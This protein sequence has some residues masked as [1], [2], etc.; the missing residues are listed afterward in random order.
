MSRALDRSETWSLNAADLRAWIGGLIGSGARVVAPA[1]H[2]GLW[3]FRPLRS[4]EELALPAGFSAWSPKEFLFPRTETLFR[5]E[6]SGGELGLVDPAREDVPQVLFGLAPCDAAG[7]A[8]LD[9]VLGADP[10]YASRRALT[11]VV[12]LACDRARPE[13]FCTTVGGS[14]QGEEG[15]DL[16]LVANDETFLLRPLTE[17]GASLV[18]LASG[19]WAPA[20]AEA[21]ERARARLREVAEA[22]GQSPLARGFA[23]GLEERF[24][25]PAWRQVGRR[26]LGCSICTYVCP[27]C[28][29]FDVQDEGSASCGQRCRVWDS[30]TFGLFTLH[31]SGHNPR[32]SQAARYRQ[33]VLHK[34]SSYPLEHGGTPM[35]VGCGRCVRLCPAGLDVRETVEQVLAAGKEPR[36]AGA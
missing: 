6:V 28:S 26:C 15:G 5:Y 12:T 14:P 9:S 22:V 30:C 1:E 25:S 13:C 18:S 16:L 23:E 32:P 21:W 33:R 35:C 20:T 8:R 34:F 36:H 19:H 7:L 17:K 29:C 10:A 27:S 4:G 31:A 11:T 24:G 2:G 3:T